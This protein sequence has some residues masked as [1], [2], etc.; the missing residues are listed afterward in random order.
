[1]AP[2]FRGILRSFLLSSPPPQGIERLREDQ[3]QNHFELLKRKKKSFR[4]QGFPLFAP[5]PCG[6]NQGARGDGASASGFPRLFI[7]HL[8]GT[9][10]KPNGAPESETP[11][12]YNR[13]IG[14][15]TRVTLHK[16]SK[17]P[18]VMSSGEFNSWWHDIGGCRSLNSITVSKLQIREFCVT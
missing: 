2:S 18:S 16:L 15:D 3:T 13:C 10:T 4:H 12:S 17:F 6:W 9:E 5:F 7:R 8:L 1:M 14:R 11:G